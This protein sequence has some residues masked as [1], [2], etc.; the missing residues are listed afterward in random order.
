LHD[1]SRK[2][3]SNNEPKPVDEVTLDLL[4]SRITNIRDRT[5]MSL[6][7]ATGLRISEMHQLDRDSITIESVED[8]AQG[9]STF[10]AQVKSWVRATN[11]ARSLSTKKTCY[12]YDEYLVTELT[13]IRRYFFQRESSVFRSAL[14]ST[15]WRHCARDSAVPTSTCTVCVTVLRQSWPIV[16]S[17]A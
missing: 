3:K 11:V 8:D 6:F 10:A 2:W 15:P 14:S 9:Q 5:L 17:A 12:L 13:T 7:L 1:L 4:I 16:T